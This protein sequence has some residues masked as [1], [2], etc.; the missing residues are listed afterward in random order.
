MHV[1]IRDR[2]KK[3]VYYLAHSFR[4]NGNVRKIRKY[5][6][7]DLTEEKI[8]L[9]RKDAEK[10]ILEQI[11]NYKKIRDPLHTVLSTKETLII[12][13]MI[14]PDKIKIKH[15][16]EKE[17]T[18]FIENFAYDTNAIEGSTVTYLEVKNILEKDKWPKDRTKWEISETYGV[19]DAIKYI[20]RTRDSVSLNLIKELHR[21][22]FKNSK[23]FAGKFREPGIEVV[24][25][26]NRGNILHRGA[27]QKQVPFLLKELIK[28][29]EKNKTNYHPIVI[30]SVVHNQFETIHPFQ[31]G[32][33]RVGRLL[34][35]NILLKYNLPPVNIELKRRHEYYSILREY[36]KTGN[37]RPTIEFILK[38][39]NELKKRFKNV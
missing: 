32:N 36:Q 18:K 15:L 1:E 31:D 16:S 17:W 20:R 23:D 14:S 39:Y 22:V 3:K 34:L 2:G 11:M 21:I 19:A 38:E 8:K 6:G 10:I 37:I 7:S 13:N 26:D 29:Y 12:R 33:G 9:L 27:P 4:D 35:N 25:A 30:A 28:W 5:L 24:V